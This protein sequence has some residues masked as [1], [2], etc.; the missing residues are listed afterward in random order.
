MAGLRRTGPELPSNHS[1]SCKN[2][3]DEQTDISAGRPSQIIARTIHHQR[4]YKIPWRDDEPSTIA[5]V[6]L[7]S[8]TH[9]H[10][11]LSRIGETP[12]L[13]VRTGEQSEEL[14]HAACGAHDPENGFQTP[15]Y[16]VVGCD[17]RRY[18]DPHRGFSLPNGSA[19]PAGTFFLHTANDFLGIQGITE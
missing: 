3:K 14:C 9:S 4:K 12:P 10:K 5:S 2:P 15:V 1:H 6:G 8:K 13:S 18:T 17:P 16:V 11:C 7:P 19:A